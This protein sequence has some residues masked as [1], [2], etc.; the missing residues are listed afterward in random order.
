MLFYNGDALTPD[1]AASG[2]TDGDAAQVIYYGPTEGYAA[3]E[4]SHPLNSLDAC[5]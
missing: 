3:I 1:T 5:T 4:F 2:T